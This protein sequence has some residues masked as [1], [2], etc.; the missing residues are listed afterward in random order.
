MRFSGMTLILLILI[1]VSVS[2]QSKEEVTESDVEN[3]IREH[4]ISAIDYQKSSIN[5]YY[6]IFN[7]TSE[8][9]GIYVLKSI[10]DGRFIYSY[11]AAKSDQ[12]TSEE[13]QKSN[14]VF[15]GGSEDGSV[16]LMI[17]SEGI[18]KKIHT[19][20]IVPR[21]GQILFFDIAT[22][23]GTYVLEEDDL[24]KDN[25]VNAYIRDENFKIIEY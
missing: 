20:A 4:N 1:L 3:F 19:V 14:P 21:K 16:G 18:L 7:R 22:D 10:E 13:F 2:C 17:Q 9:I 11:T 23:K 24:L 8:E 15:I 12:S 25:I 5:D 6:Y